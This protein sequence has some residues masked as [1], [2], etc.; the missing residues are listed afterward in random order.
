MGESV[1]FKRGKNNIVIDTELQYDPDD[2]A[3]VEI[4]NDASAFE[5]R[6]RFVKGWVTGGTDPEDG[7]VECGDGTRFPLEVT[8]EQMMEIHFRVKD[9]KFT[10]GAMSVTRGS[11]EEPAFFELTDV[12]PTER[13]IDWDAHPDFNEYTPYD[14]VSARGFVSYSENGS[15]E[16]EAPENYGEDPEDYPDPP[17]Q[18]YGD[19][20]KEPYYVTDSFEF[21]NATVRDISD[22][23]KAMWAT[24]Y[25]EDE[26]PFFGNANHYIGDF[27]A[28]NLFGGP[29]AHAYTHADNSEFEFPSFRTGFNQ[30][31]W[32][33]YVSQLSGSRPADDPVGLYGIYG[34]SPIGDD[35]YSSFASFNFFKRVAFVDDTG[36]GDPFDPGNRLFLEAS[37]FASII[38]VAYGLTTN[39]EVVDQQPFVSD[40]PEVRDTINL[41]VKLSGGA[42]VSCPLYFYNDETNELDSSTDFVIEAIEWWPYAKKDGS[43]AYDS[44]TGLPI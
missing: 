33:E 39:L 26:P 5:P 19:W 31:F 34:K 30:S 2:D 43:P 38:G 18:Q 1:S 35:G 40:P 42:E 17:M 14:A 10:A 32:A 28:S 7:S 8:V 44:S 3:F 9:A 41:T 4:A 22:N 12:A 36:S 27:S 29:L 24:V 23:E 16:F 25:S 11:F 13:L 15:T 21:V 6:L 20:F 37:F